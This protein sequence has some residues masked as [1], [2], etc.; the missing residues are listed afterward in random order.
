MTLQRILSGLAFKA[1]RWRPV[2]LLGGWFFSHM[3]FVLPVQRLRQTPTLVAFYHPQPAHAVHVLIVPRR[4]ISG[5]DALQPQDQ[6][7]LIDLFQ[8]VQ[9]LVRELGLHERGYRLVANGGRSQDIPQ[10]HFHLIAD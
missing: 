4:A 2:G 3:S 8:V 6:D 5:L 9:S 7:F 10:L 1:A